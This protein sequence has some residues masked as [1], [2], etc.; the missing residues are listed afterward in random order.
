MYVYAPMG[1]KLNKSSGSFLP[2]PER[3][4]APGSYGC[5]NPTLINI[6]NQSKSFSLN[7]LP[8]T[9]NTHVYI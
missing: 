3:F 5:I 2:T 4:V 7:D 6:T 8:D 1:K 9:Y